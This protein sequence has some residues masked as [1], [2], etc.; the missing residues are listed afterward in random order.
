MIKELLDRNDGF[1]IFGA[2]VI[3]YG[4][5]CAI[6]HLYGVVPEC[7]VVSSLDNNPN[8]IDGVRVA[9]TD[10]IAKDKLIIVG[11]TELVQKEVVPQLKEQGYNNLF[12]LTQHEE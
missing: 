5:Y 9:T 11:V 6:K 4:A 10:T 7:F 12:V 3:A 8:E 1:V 2:Q